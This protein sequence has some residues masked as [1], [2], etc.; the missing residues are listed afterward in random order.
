MP[1]RKQIITASV[2]IVGAFGLSQF[3]RLG[4]NLVVTRLLEPEMFGLMAIIYVVLHGVNMFSDLGFWSFIV[5]H[6]QGTEKKILDTVWSMQ[7][8]RGCL[9]CIVLFMLAIILSLTSSV[10]KIDLGSVYG[11]SVLPKILIVVGVGAII[12]GYKSMA[13]AIASRDLKRGRLEII[14]LVSQL[15]GIT[16]MLIWAWVEPT[17]WALVAAGVVSGVVNVMLTYQLF[18]YRHHFAWNQE[19]VN[20]VFVYGKWIFIASALTYLAL[21][22]DKII[23]ASYISASQLG[24]Y[25]IAFMLSGVVSNVFQ[26]LNSKI[27]FPILSKTVNIEPQNLKTKYYSIR[28]KQDIIIFF[29]IGLLIALSPNLIE[30]LYDE[31]FHEAGWMMQILSFSLVGL[32]LSSL[33]LECLSALSITKIRMKVM[34]LRA[35]TVFIG[36]P[37]L[38]SNYGFLG[39]IWGVV[40]GSFISIPIQYM[41]M[42]KQNIFSFLHEV[43]MLPLIGIGYLCGHMLL[44]L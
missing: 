18:G 33:G 39:A 17:V 26:Q 16:V 19:I 12:N 28:S 36:L 7:I 9:M 5:R 38:F 11:N 32:A 29:L 37:I 3:V 20:E 13:P 14:E 10:L 2:W 4:S 43:R 8:V 25:S 35:L 30:F 41:E 27:W 44:E 22:G 6:P 23:F 31:R 15:T 24:V 40:L 42:K 21:Q 1:N 34:F